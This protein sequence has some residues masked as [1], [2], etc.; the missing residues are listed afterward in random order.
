MTGIPGRPGDGTQRDHR[1]ETPDQRQ[2]AGTDGRQKIPTSGPRPLVLDSVTD[3]VLVQVEE[4]GI[5]R[6]GL[7]A[8]L[9][10]ELLALDGHRSLELGA[11]LMVQRDRPED[12]AGF[13]VHLVPSRRVSG[14]TW[15][16]AHS[17]GWHRR[18]GLVVR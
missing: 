5:V 9:G 4:D 16:G 15:G 3:L 7:A 17:R 10:D 13:V 1:A 6:A 12:L 11:R 14:V 8:E 2:Q 18:L